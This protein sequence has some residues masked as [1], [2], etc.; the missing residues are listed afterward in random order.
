MQIPEFTISGVA[1]VDDTEGGA[2]ILSH[3]FMIEGTKNITGTVSGE[4]DD[5]GDVDLIVQYTCGN[6]PFPIKQ[7]FETLD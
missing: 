4:F 3:P 6:M 5:D 7:E 2:S 1:V